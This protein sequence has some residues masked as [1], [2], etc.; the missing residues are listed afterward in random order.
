MTMSELPFDAEKLINLCRLRY[1]L[2]AIA[3]IE[4][5]LQGKERAASRW[6]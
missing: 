3:R 5:Y 4:A 2:A 1:M 6:G